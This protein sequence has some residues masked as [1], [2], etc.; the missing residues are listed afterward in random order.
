ML[1]ADIEDDRNDHQANLATLQQISQLAH[2]NQGHGNQDHHGSKLK[3]FQN[4][5]PPIFQ[6]S[7]EPLDAND[8]IQ[9]MENNLEDAGVDATEKVLFGT[10]YLAGSAR[11]W[12]NSTCTMN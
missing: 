12:W 1:V 3:N 8:W 7:E 10:H 9:T 4:T 6:K 5:N 2:D 11:E